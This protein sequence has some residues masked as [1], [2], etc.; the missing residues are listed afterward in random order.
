MKKPKPLK[1]T[2]TSPS[3]KGMGD[4]YGTGVRNRVAKTVDVF[5]ATPVKAKNIGKAPRS[6]A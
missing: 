1:N 3:Q 2:H 6:V 4:Y 5:T